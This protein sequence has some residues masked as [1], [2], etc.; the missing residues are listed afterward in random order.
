[1]F[2]DTNQGVGNA[3][4]Y[5][6]DLSKII[7]YV[8]KKRNNIFVAIPDNG[9]GIPQMDVENIFLR[10]YRVSGSANSFPGSGVGLYI[11][12]EIIKIHGGEIWAES[13]IGKGFVFH[14]LFLLP[15][16]IKNQ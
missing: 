13:E 6:P 9:I 3:I 4:K 2:R 16:Q 10:F 14:F 15:Y 8:G 1:M 11:S 5:T 12:S 7:I